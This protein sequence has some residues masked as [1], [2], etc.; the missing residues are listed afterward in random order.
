MFG[1][2]SIGVSGFLVK[3]VPMILIQ[4]GHSFVSNESLARPA[5]GSLVRVLAGI[6]LISVWFH[7]ALNE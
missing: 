1:V 3:L 7:Y 4:S 6:L 5:L 2:E